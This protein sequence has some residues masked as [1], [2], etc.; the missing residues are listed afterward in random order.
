MIWVWTDQKYFADKALLPFRVQ[1]AVQCLQV[2]WSAMSYTIDAGI[3][4]ICLCQVKAK[5]STE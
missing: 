2:P 5:F 1:F 3:K 4:Y